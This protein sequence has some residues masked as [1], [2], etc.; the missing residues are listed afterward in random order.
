MTLDPD[1]LQILAC[2]VCRNSLDLMGDA[3]GLACP[4]CAVVYPIRDEIPVMLAEES[5]PARE[6]AAGKRQALPASS[7]PS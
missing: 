6:W 2:P 5:V 1:L 7:R 3:E 4:R